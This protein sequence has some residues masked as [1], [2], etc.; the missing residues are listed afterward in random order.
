[1]AVNFTPKANYDAKRTPGN[2]SPLTPPPR[3]P[4]AGRVGRETGDFS[5][6]PQSDRAQPAPSAGAFARAR[7]AD[8]PRGDRRL[9]RREPQPPGCRSAGVVRRSALR[10]ARAD[11]ERRAG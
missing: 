7:G 6:L 1:M 11:N 9:R 8:L 3:R 10:R 4:D 2:A 5:E